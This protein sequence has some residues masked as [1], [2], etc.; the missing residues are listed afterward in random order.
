MKSYKE[1]ERERERAKLRVRHNA[2]CGAQ[3]TAY[4]F[5]HAHTYAYE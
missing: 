4:N 2:L 3:C 5:K 1:R